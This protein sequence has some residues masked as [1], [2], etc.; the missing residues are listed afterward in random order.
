MRCPRNRGKLKVN[1][2]VNVN[3]N[4]NV[5]LDVDADVHRSAISR[6]ARHST[7]K[8]PAPPP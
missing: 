7:W 3:V 5:N 4:V 6:R 1:D 2:H 8:V